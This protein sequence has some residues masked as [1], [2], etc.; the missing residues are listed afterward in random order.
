MKKNLMFLVL[1]LFTCFAKADLYDDRAAIAA[2]RSYQKQLAEA[3]AEAASTQQK[4]LKNIENF[5][6]KFS[7]YARKPE[8]W[9]IDSDDSRHTVVE[10]VCSKTLCVNVKSLATKVDY[11][12]SVSMVWMALSGRTIGGCR[13]VLKNGLAC[14]IGYLYTA[15]DDEHREYGG[16]CYDA[17]GNAKELKITSAR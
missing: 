17:G 14:S 3:K 6:K 4:K 12:Q 13:V 11:T 16:T 15:A 2:N 9:Q 8:C 5:G 10:Q 7:G 1:S